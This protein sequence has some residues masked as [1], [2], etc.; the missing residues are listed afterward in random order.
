MQE[1]YVEDCSN[2]KVNGI[3]YL[4]LKKRETASWSKEYRQKDIYIA[5]LHTEWSLQRPSFAM[6]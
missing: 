6:L 2:Y 3:P 5:D 4:Q 1:Y